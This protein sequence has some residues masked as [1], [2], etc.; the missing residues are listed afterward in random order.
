MLRVVLRTATVV[1][2]MAWAAPTFGHG[3]PIVVTVGSGNRLAVSG[4]VA[5]AEDGRVGQIYVETDSAGDPQDFAD[6]TNFGPAVYWN[7]P[8]FEISGLAENSGLYLQTV[9][10]PVR[11]TNPVESRLLW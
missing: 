1:A 11:G 6:F 9:A 5:G 10:R 7:V 2:L 8:G 4:G 3:H